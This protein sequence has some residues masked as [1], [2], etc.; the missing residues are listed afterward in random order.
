MT[1]KEI[2]NK[3]LKFFE[4]RGHLVLPSASLIPANDPSILWTAA[5]MVP[6]KPYFT[7]AT[8]PV[9]RRITTC[10]KCLR[11]PDIESVG[12]TSRHHTFFEMLG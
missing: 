10:Q 6:F 9:A 11:T 4:E 3:F 12:M 7:G 2:R 1:G 8:T 5:G